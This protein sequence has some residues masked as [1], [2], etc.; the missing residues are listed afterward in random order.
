MRSVTTKVDM[1][2][3]GIVVMELLT[4]RRPTALFL[5]DGSPTTFHQLAE[6][7]LANGTEGIL[8]V[9]DPA[10]VMDVAKQKLEM[11]E[12]LFRLAHN[13]TAPNPGDRPD[14]SEVLATLLKI[15]G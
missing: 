3:F 1:F 14:M 2:S 10:L 12:A 5:D 11:L 9:L 6:V 8:E 15:K 13:C 7:A 4:R